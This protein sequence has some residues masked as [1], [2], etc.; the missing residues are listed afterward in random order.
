MSV[1][2][3][4]DS[5]REVQIERDRL[6]GELGRVCYK[7]EINYQQSLVLHFLENRVRFIQFNEGEFTL[8][9]FSAREIETLKLQSR[10]FL[11][12]RI[13]VSGSNNSGSN[14]LSLD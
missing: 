7:S 11:R 5:V 3:S 9:T 1:W 10:Q 6:E 8:F 12:Q 4:R 14:Q 2:K 13:A